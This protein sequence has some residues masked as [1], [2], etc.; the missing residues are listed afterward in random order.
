MEGQTKE[1]PV[2]FPG[3]RLN[4]A[5]NLLYRNDDA[6]AITATGES[7]IV[8][9]YSFRKLQHLVRRMAAA[10]RVNGLQ[11]GDRVAA[12]VTNST[13]AIVIALATISIGAIFSSTATDMGTQGIL[14]RY[15]QIRPKFVFAETEVVYSGKTINLLGKVSE[16]IRDLL[17]KGLQKAVLLPSAKTGQDTGH[18]IPQSINLSAF[19]D[20]GDNRELRFEQL[21]FDHPVFIL[22]SSGTTGKPKCIVHSGGGVLLQTK[23]EAR[24]GFDSSPSD[25][26]LQFTTTAWMMW[27]FQLVGLACGARIILYDGSPFYPDLSTYLRLVNDQG[28]TVLGT[29]PRFLAEVL[30]QGI[31]PLVDIG[32][33]ED[34]RTLMVTGAVLTPPMFEWA[35]Q[36]FGEHIHID[37]TSGGTD[38]CTS[39]VTGTPSLPVYA[40]EIQGKALGMKTEVFDPAGNNIEHTGQPGELVCTRPH[41]SLPVCF[42]GDPT[43]EKFRDAYFS[44]YPGVWRQGDFIVANPATKGLMILGRSDGVLNPSGVRF[45]SAEIYSVLEKF[46]GILEDSICVG[47]RRPQDIDEHVLLFVKMRAGHHFTRALEDEIR[48]SIRTRLSARHVPSYIFEVQEIPY[49]VNGKKIEIAVKQIVSG[50]NVQPSATVAN[51]ESL[52][53]YYKYRDLEFA[54]AKL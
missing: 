20:T 28:I 29:S 6:I 18:N 51:P 13:N 22:Y 42:W 38:I 2:W 39:F 34:L 40:G 11:S 25:T 3:A 19:L 31:K 16:V 46:S 44:M 37:S 49:T 5:E 30:G 41:P 52:C 21:P 24:L 53:L 43:G 35:Q 23:K 17:D 14:D 45:G 10:L 27:N 7:G 15:R 50:I 36:A 54:R 48:S 9:N 33:F 26:Y 47:Q 4:Y 1:V 12:I 32:K 8:T